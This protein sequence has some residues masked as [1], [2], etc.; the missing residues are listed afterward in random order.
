MVV[1]VWVSGCVCVRVW[2]GVT[3][4]KTND[5]NFCSHRLFIGTFTTKN[6]NTP[7]RLVA[8]LL[9]NKFSSGSQ[10]TKEKMKWTSLAARW[11]QTLRFVKYL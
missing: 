4:T 5:S 7:C 6:S 3:T 1:V 9:L 2:R 10:M 11:C 8:S